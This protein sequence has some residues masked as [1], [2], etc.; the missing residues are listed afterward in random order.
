MPGNLEAPRILPEHASGV[1]K[2]SAENPYP[3]TVSPPATARRSRF[4][5]G[6]GGTTTG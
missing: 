1:N 4:E 2:K 3:T 5:V 6:T